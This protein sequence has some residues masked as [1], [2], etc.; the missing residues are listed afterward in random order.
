VISWIAD[1]AEPAEPWIAPIRDVISSVALAVC[2]LFGPG[3][4]CS[5]E[6]PLRP[7]A[8]SIVLP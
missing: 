3:G 5:A 8:R 7:G 1:P 2:R 4:I 6:A